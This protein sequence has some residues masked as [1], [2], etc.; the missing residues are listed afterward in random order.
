MDRINKVMINVYKEGK[1]SDERKRATLQEIRKKK[2][3][4]HPIPIVSTFFIAI[5]CLLLLTTIQPNKLIQPNEQA[6]YVSSVNVGINLEDVYMERILEG[7]TISTDAELEEYL[8]ESD[9]LLQRALESTNSIFYS[10]PDLDQWERHD[11]AALLHYLYNWRETYGTKTL[12]IDTVE[13]FYEVNKEAPFYVKVLSDFLEDGVYR[14]AMEEKE[15]IPVTFFGAMSQGNQ[16]G[17]IC[18]IVVF[19]LLFI[20]NIKSRVNLFFKLIPIAIIL[21]CLVPFVSPVG[22]DYAYD[23]TSLMRVAQEKLDFEGGVL[24]NAATF[25]GARYGLISLNDKQHYM[26]TFIKDEH[27]YNFARS[28]GGSGMVHFDMLMGMNEG[29]NI[30]ITGF[31]EGHPYSMVKLVGDNGHEVEIKVTPGESIIKRAVMPNDTYRYYYYDEAGNEI[32]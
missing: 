1:F 28:N 26:V 19:I 12:P 4:I 10:S 27:G 32:K 21:M 24:E 8:S 30:Y 2:R 9:W 17:L 16:I 13:T 14:T 6:E 25:D 23:E 15:S 22:N 11:L 7:F 31:F 20:W 3:S 18:T 5:L 29:K